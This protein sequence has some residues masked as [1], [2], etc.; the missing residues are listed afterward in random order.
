MRDDA[1]AVQLPALGE[2]LQNQQVEAP[3]QIVSRHAFTPMLRTP[4]LLGMETLPLEV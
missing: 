3:L 4:A 2:G 1:I